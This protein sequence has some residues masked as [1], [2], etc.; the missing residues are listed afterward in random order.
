MSNLKRLFR[1]LLRKGWEHSNTPQVKLKPLENCRGGLV[2]R[3][4]VHKSLLLKL[5]NQQEYKLF[6]S[7]RIYFL[8]GLQT[9]WAH[10]ST[11]WQYLKVP[12][13]KIS[14]HYIHLQVTDRQ[15]IHKYQILIYQHINK[16]LRLTKLSGGS[17]GSKCTPHTTRGIMLV[18]TPI[19][20]LKVYSIKPPPS[21]EVEA[22]ETDKF[23]KGPCLSIS[24]G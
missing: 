2:I 4:A 14:W 10:N 1:R 8:Q 13:N 22:M 19:V 21:W 16:F 11:Q 3:R 7:T 6:I 9:L 5:C 18:Q 12:A 17:G 20:L 24:R 23:T 15:E